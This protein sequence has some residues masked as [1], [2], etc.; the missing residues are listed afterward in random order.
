MRPFYNGERLRETIDKKIDKFEVL[1]K[2]L[3]I[4]MKNC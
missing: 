1:E 4:L 3:E 2:I